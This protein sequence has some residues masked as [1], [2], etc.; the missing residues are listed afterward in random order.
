MIHHLKA[1][2]WDISDYTINQRPSFVGRFTLFCFLFVLISLQT[3]ADEGVKQSFQFKKYYNECMVQLHSPEV[4]KMADTLYNEACQADNRYYQVLARFVRLDYYYFKDD[5]EMFLKLVPELK[6]MSREYNQLEEYY[7]VWGSRLITFYLRSGMS[8]HALVEAQ[9]MLREAEKDKF[10]LGI[11]ECY[12]A[13]ANIYLVQSNP[14]QAA[15]YFRR[16]ID[17]INESGESDINMPTYYTALI[18]SLLSSQQVKEAEETLKQSRIYLSKVDSVTDY[19]KLCLAQSELELYSAKKDGKRAKEA[20]HNIEEL[21]ATSNKM[22]ILENSLQECRLRYYL[23][24]KDYP[25]ALATMDSINKHT[26]DSDMSQFVL[27]NRAEVYWDMNDRATAANYYRSYINATDS[28]RKQSMQKS[29]DEIAGIFNTRQLEQEKQSLKI[30]IQNRRLATTY[31]AIG[32]LVVILLIAAIVIVYIYRLNRRLKESKQVV[33]SQNEALIRSSEESKEA[34]ERAEAASRMK[35]DFIQNITHEVRTPL[36]SIVGFSQV[37][38]ESN[39]N[40]E[41]EE[42]ASLITENSVCLLRLFDDVLEL[43]NIDRME[44]LPYDAADDINSSCRAAIAEVKP[45]VQ[46]GV[47]LVFCPSEEHLRIKTNCTYVKLIISYLLHNAAKFT[48]SGSI[49]LEY[50]VSPPEGVIRYLLTDTGIGIPSQQ[51]EEVFER[52]KKLDIF[53]QGSGLGLSVARAIAEKLGGT[54]CID[55]T[56]TAGARFVLV[57]PFIAE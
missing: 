8:N 21:F 35:T 38:A 47:E 29:A 55:S 45:C 9:N 23:S 48:Q 14:R 27:F 4:L 6:R 17:V 54:L 52:F 49:T 1:N 13:M 28:M 7:F 22:S 53:T 32:A 20:M 5:K 57:L 44:Q 26:S 2:Q 24:V 40:P 34:K 16:L 15:Y 10:Q 33:E 37:L 39:E 25:R 43:S 51:H 41:T 12:K 19:H 56:Y 31:W 46:E 36:N 50:E 30:D 18:G 11:A 3:F 42:F